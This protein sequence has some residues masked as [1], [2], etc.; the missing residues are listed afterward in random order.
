MQNSNNKIKPLNQIVE[1]AS[2]L[3]SHNKKI[4]TTNGVFDILHLGHVN[5]LEEAKKLGDVLIVGINSDASVRQIKGPKRPIN[6][7]ECRAGIL[8]GLASVDYV[9]IFDDSN[10]SSWIEKIKP[11]I[12]AKASDYRMEQ[13]MEKETVEKNNG[14][15]VLINAEKQYSTTKLIE[16]ILEV[17]KKIQP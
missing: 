4:V 9:F 12:H 10:P 2:K 5:Y 17:Y 16:K 3:K 14:K 8:A 13:I 15:V 7:E 6:S 1:I 11:N